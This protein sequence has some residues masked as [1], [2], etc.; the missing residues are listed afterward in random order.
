MFTGSRRVYDALHTTVANLH[1]GKLEKEKRGKKAKS[2]FRLLYLL[3]TG[4]IPQRL[5][6]SWLITMLLFIED[7]HPVTNN[8]FIWVLLLLPVFVYRLFISFIN[9]DVKPFVWGITLLCF[10]MTRR[11]IGCHEATHLCCLYEWLTKSERV[12]DLSSLSW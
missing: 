12:N 10:Q 11:S 6:A 8:L 1:L 5:F 7:F 9:C 2:L 4:S 3:L